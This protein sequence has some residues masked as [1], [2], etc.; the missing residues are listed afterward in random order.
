M[1]ILTPAQVPEEVVWDHV[2]WL[3]KISRV[4]NYNLSWKSLPVLSHPH[5]QNVFPDLQTVS[6]ASVVLLPLVLALGTTENS[7]LF[8]P[9]SQVFINSDEIS[10]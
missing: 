6:P 8:A 2:K 4:K 5:S 7:S 3:L 1:L 9:S 10:S